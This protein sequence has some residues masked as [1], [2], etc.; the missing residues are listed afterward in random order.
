MRWLL[1][2]LVVLG[3]LIISS[4]RRVDYHTLRA[5]LVAKYEC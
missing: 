1:I 4:V 2:V 5:D 3:G